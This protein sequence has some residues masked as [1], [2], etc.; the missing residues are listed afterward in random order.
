MF[1]PALIWVLSC[2]IS[3]RWL[4]HLA[5][6]FLVSFGVAALGSNQSVD[7]IV[8]TDHRKIMRQHDRPR[9]LAEISKVGGILLAADNSAIAR[10]FVI[11]G[12]SDGAPRWSRSS[13]GSDALTDIEDAEPG[14][15]HVLPTMGSLDN[16][17]SD[18]VT[19]RR[20]ARRSDVFADPQVASGGSQKTVPA[21]NKSVP[22]EETPTI[23]LKILSAEKKT[24]TAVKAATVE[25][26]S[27]LEEEMKTVPADKTSVGDLKI[28]SAE[29]K[30][31]NAMLSLA[32][33]PADD[34]PQAWVDGVQLKGRTGKAGGGWHADAC[35]E[36]VGDAE[37]PVRWRPC[38]T[39]VAAQ[40]WSKDPDGTFRS[41]MNNT[42][43]KRGSLIS[44]GGRYFIEL[45][46]D[47]AGANSL[48]KQSGSDYKLDVGHGHC[49]TQSDPW[50]KGKV[51]DDAA[52]TYTCG[53]AHSILAEGDAVKASVAVPPPLES[54]T[55]TAMCSVST[56]IYSFLL[57]LLM[58]RLSWPLL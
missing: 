51:P 9:L 45:S 41:A 13:G 58:N 4:I 10:S 8:S 39:D 18:A 40:A 31:T 36:I 22:V 32:D 23:D 48:Q 49:L 42:C 1:L 11:A 28:V 14:E 25:T 33:P 29:Q 34:L 12:T 19:S 38:E 30:N 2:S 16:G 5:M 47:C 43:I 52:I 37:N 57:L 55:I 44:P 20:S 50:T 15:V 35:L 26:T 21:E 17:L 54:S 6:P 46:T 7:I 53:S 3:P 56:C 24:V 27:V